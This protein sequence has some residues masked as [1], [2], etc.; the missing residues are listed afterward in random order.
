M[1]NITIGRMAITLCLLL[2]LLPG[3]GIELSASQSLINSPSV[4]VTVKGSGRGKIEEKFFVCLEADPETMPMPDGGRDGRY[5][6]TYDGPGT[7]YIPPIAFD[8]IGVY[9]YRI[10]QEKGNNPLCRYDERTYRL[11]IYVTC[12]ETAGMAL[13]MS[14]TLHN[15]DGDEKVTEIIF[16]NLFDTPETPHTG[17]RLSAGLP[18]ALLLISLAALALV[19]RRRECQEG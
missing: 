9:T 14:A 13:Q 8:A 7:Q 11:T 16:E 10:Y 1:K 6:M 18:A 17:D 19:L 15:E 4:P 5:R 3:A 2:W 12:E